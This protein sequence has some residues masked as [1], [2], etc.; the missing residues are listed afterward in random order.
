MGERAQKKSSN[1][2][3]TQSTRAP[4]IGEW[5]ICGSVGISACT[6]IKCCHLAA[7]SRASEQPSYLE[8]VSLL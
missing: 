5:R 3:K 7:S 1:R 4:L 2:G 6:R 8:I